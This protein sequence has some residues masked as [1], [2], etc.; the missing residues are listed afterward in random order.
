MTAVG[1]REMGDGQPPPDS[2]AGWI[3]KAMPRFFLRDSCCPR[4]LLDAYNFAVPLRI[5]LGQHEGDLGHSVVI[6]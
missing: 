4:K 1:L 2:R 3:F 6:P 5:M